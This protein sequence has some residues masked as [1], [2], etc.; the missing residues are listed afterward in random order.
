MLLSLAWG[1]P[2]VAQ[3]AGDAEADRQAPASVQESD[4]TRIVI[5][6]SGG[7][8]IPRSDRAEPAILIE[9]GGENYLFDTGDGVTR[10]LARA[11]VGPNDLRAIF[12]SHLHLDHVGGL[13]YL[14]G[15]RWVYR[16][17]GP[18]PVI[19]PAGTARLIEGS[20]NFLAVP[21]DLFTPTLPKGLTVAESVDVREVDAGEA[22]AIIVYQDDNITVRAIGNSH[23]ALLPPELRAASGGS[24]AYRI[25]A[26]DR[27]VVYTGDTGPSEAVIRLARGADIL[28]SEVVDVEATLQYLTDQMGLPPARLGAQDR[29]QRE[30]HLTPQEVGRIAREAGVGMVVLTHLVPGLDSERDTRRY[31]DGVRAE[32]AGP[33][34]VASDL[35]EY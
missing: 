17:A 33:V 11:G 26:A 32:F 8:P 23:L 16:P 1:S 28:I 6:G 19:G 20:G 31:S 10:Q 3:A 2:A 7:G 15:A 35:A 27:S 4:A 18:L 13:P 29:F 12:L 30:A 14:V 5:L 21:E 9:A 22:E 25:D 34:V 24:F